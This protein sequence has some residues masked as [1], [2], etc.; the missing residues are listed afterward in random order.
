[1]VRVL[2]DDGEEPFRGENHPSK[3]SP[4]TVLDSNEG[5]N[6]FLGEGKKLQK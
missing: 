6:T 3:L 1:M 4:F 2:Y 5:A